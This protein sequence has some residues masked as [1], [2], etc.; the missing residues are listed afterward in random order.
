M[1]VEEIT[2]TYLKFYTV[3]EEKARLPHILE[4]KEASKQRLKSMKYF[5]ADSEGIRQEENK[6]QSRESI[7]LGR[8]DRKESIFEEARITHVQLTRM[9]SEAHIKEVGDKIK[10]YL[11]GEFKIMVLGSTNVGKSTF[12]NHLI[13]KG[14]VLL[15]SE[16]RETSCLWEIRF[17]DSRP[18]FGVKS[19]YMIHRNNISEYQVFGC[20]TLQ[21]MKSVVSTFKLKDDADPA[22]ERKLQKV[23]LTLPHKT[24]MQEDNTHRYRIIDIPGLEDSFWQKSLQSYI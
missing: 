23:Q 21:D 2:R 17:D 10:K 19:K 3:A 16:K 13:G 5:V 24:F 11:R 12:L 4:E 22:P 7:Y 20:A 15:T 18:D 6:M 8:F 1:T 14:A 9:F